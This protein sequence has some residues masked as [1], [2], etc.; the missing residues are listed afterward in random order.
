VVLNPKRSR[1]YYPNVA[2]KSRIT[3]IRDN[4]AWAFARGEANS[5][6]F[7]YGLDRIGGPRPDDFLSKREEMG[8]IAK[9]IAVRQAQGVVDLLKDKQAFGD[10][11][12]RHGFPAARNVA[13]LDRNGVT[14]CGPPHCHTPLATFVA[15][16]DEIDGIAKPSKGHG[17][18]DVFSLR[19]RSGAVLINGQPVDLANL[20]A[21][22]R[23]PFLLQERVLQ[24]ERLARLHPAS[25]NT[26]RL[27]TVLLGGEVTPLAALVRIG[28][29]G[30]V[31]DNLGSGGIVVRLDL[32]RGTL[33]GPGF[34]LPGHGTTCSQHP[35]SGVQ[36]DGYE[37]PM[38]AEALDLA[39][40]FH[41]A[42]Q[43]IFTVGWDIAITPNGPCVLE[44]NSHWRGRLYM[45][46]EPGY[47]AKYRGLMKELGAE[48]E[49]TRS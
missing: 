12:C 21:R 10:F 15:D 7:L 33:D 6:Y 23:E 44:G 19:I 9:Q 4:L 43:P 2:R 42:L 11:A 30:S 35:N 31:V 39:V 1:T 41:R 48:S 34:Y 40:S 24:H 36:L 26:L 16:A 38:V 8:L 27:T 3:M 47:H 18:R 5:L 37:I 45:A 14:E 17:G 28:T 22:I 29:N 13:V 32:A 25:I 46:F 49:P 20:A